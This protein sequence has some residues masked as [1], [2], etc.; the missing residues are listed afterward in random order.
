MG[1]YDMTDAYM[2]GMRD[3]IIS[4]VIMFGNF[5]D[6]IYQGTGYVGLTDA[7]QDKPF[8]QRTSIFWILHKIR[9]FPQ[10]IHTVSSISF[11]PSKQHI[12][13]ARKFLASRN[14]H[15]HSIA[16]ATQTTE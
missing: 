12:T 8:E 9:N 16:K 3:P 10:H 11:C 15:F 1:E 14:C 5:M 7:Y 4:Q 6:Y 2:Q 13:I